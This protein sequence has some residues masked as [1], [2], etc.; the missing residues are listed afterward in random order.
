MF[1]IS[2]VWPF[3][4]LLTQPLLGHCFTLT[5]FTLLLHQ[6]SGRSPLCE[7]S[8]S[9]TCCHIPCGGN[10][11]GQQALQAWAA[12]SACCTR[13]GTQLPRYAHKKEKQRKPTQAV[14]TS[15]HLNEGK[16]AALVRSTVCPLHQKC[17]QSSR[18][19]GGLGTARGA[20]D[21]V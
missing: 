1:P 2:R 10:W 15:L 14:N 7:F 20:H 4:H 11:S 6:Y 3:T 8:H 13:T 9:P 18:G 12:S 17:T 21:V 19:I 5:W 16:A